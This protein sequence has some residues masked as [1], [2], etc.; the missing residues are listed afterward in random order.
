MIALETPRLRLRPWQ[1]DDRPALERMVRDTDMMRYVTGG[2]I[3]SD[4]AVDELLERQARHL[5]AYG[6]CF[7]AAELKAGGEVVGLVGL[8][9][10]DSGEFELG[11]WIW[12]AHWGHGLATEA[13]AA[14][15]AYARET[16]GLDTLVAVIDPPNAASRAVAEKLG[17]HFECLKSGRETIARRDDAPIA[18]YRIRF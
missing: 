3:W 13:G 10:L 2:R 8:Q 4:D 14:F 17:L 5:A 9:P 12:K 11:W 18:F 1:A 15:V 7:C 6:V 16:M